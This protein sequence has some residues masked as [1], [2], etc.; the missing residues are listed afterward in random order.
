MEAM[1]CG[2]YPGCQTKTVTAKIPAPI[3]KRKADGALE[4]G[5]RL[6]KSSRVSQEHE[7]P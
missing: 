2:T 1:G 4:M 3:G 5:T 7:R 6:L